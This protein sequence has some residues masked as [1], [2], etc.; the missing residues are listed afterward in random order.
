MMF[1]EPDNVYSE[2]IA[3]EK[4]AAYEK[5]IRTL[6]GP[7]RWE[8][9]WD[10]SI[11]HFLQQNKG[12]PVRVWNVVNGLSRGFRGQRNREEMNRIKVDI[13]RRIAVLTKRKIIRRSRRIYIFFALELDIATVATNPL[14]KG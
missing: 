14:W 11:C 4:K 8:D 1:I 2:R 9:G 7:S 6:Y 12:D 5:L 13:L 3:A 10:E